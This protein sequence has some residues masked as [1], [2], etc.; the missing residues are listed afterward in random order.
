MSKKLRNRLML[1]TSAAAVNTLY[2][3]QPFL[4]AV[5]KDVWQD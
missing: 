5:I 1:L 3:R 4:E 2:N